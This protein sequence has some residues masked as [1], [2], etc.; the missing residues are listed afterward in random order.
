VLSFG[1]FA[2]NKAVSHCT[3]NPRA[4]TISGLD[5]QS[6]THAEQACPRFTPEEKRKYKI[7]CSK[8]DR[9]AANTPSSSLEPLSYELAISTP[10][11]QGPMQTSLFSFLPKP[12]DA[13]TKK[14]IDE[15][16]VKFVVNTNSP[17]NI[18]EDPFLPTFISML[19]P[20]VD[21]QLQQSTAV[22]QR[23]TDLASKVIVGKME[24]IRKDGPWTLVFDG[25]SDV[26]DNSI[27]GFMVAK[28]EKS[29]ILAARDI[30]ANRHN[31]Q[32]LVPII[33]DVTQPFLW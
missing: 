6:L 5:C 26:S 32:T 17:L 25:W 4:L 2:I 33:Q 24:S 11:R 21:Y 29:H 9:R 14:K 8:E 19:K 12:V 10:V 16:L 3:T 23:M 13:N 1:A 7:E 18:T 30:S 22:T 31:A 20:T 28:H 15:E 27:Y